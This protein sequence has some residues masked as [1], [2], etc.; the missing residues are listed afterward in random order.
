MSITTGQNAVAS[1]FITY[2]EKNGTPANDAGRVPQLETTGKLHP[3]FVGENIQRSFTA[4]ENITA[5]EPVGISNLVPNNV[6]KAFTST[7]SVAHGVSSPQGVGNAYGSAPIPVGGDKFVWFTH[8]TAGSDTL[9]VSCA[10][11]NTATKVV[12]CGTAVTVATAFTPVT[13][14]LPTVALCKLGTDKFIIFYLLDSSAVNIK[15]RVGTISGTTI[16]LGTEAT[17][18]TSASTVATSTSFGADFISAD[19]G[20]FFHKNATVADSRVYAFTVS[21]T[22]ATAGTGVNPTYNENL[23]SRIKTIGTDKFVLVT[24]STAGSD[25]NGQ[26]FTCSGGT[27]LT[28][29]TAQ[30]LSGVGANVVAVGRLTVIS[31]ATDVF[32]CEFTQSGSTSGICSATVSTRTITSVTADLTVG[33]I[34]GSGMHYASATQLYLWDFVN[35]KIMGATISGSTLSYNSNSLAGVMPSAMLDFFTTDNGYPIAWQIDATNLIV[36]I[37]GMSN[38]ILGIA[39]SAVSAGESVNVIISGVDTNQTGLQA[40]AYYTVASGGTL[41]FATSQASTSTAQL[42]VWKAIST[43]EILVR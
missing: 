25:L 30:Q 38:N 2:A 26:V 6:A 41:T 14:Q 23:Q 32:F 20:C 21:G 12:T 11:I 40:G 19:K 33:G 28:A 35:F 16:T 1:D 37:F 42:G 29:G 5:G 8:T 15:Y 34:S 18:V 3:F 17:F 10:S 43:T 36:W 4:K 31:P 7:Y 24:V 13:T 39:Q 9:F 27:T 22:T